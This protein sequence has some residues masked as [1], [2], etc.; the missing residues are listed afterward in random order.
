[1]KSPDASHLL[2]AIKEDELPEVHGSSFTPNEMMDEPDD[3]SIIASFSKTQESFLER[4]LVRATTEMGQ[5]HATALRQQQQ[6]IHHLRQAMQTMQDKQD[7]LPTKLPA[8]ME[9]PRVPETS[10][11]RIYEPP[12]HCKTS[13]REE[14]GTR[15]AP[16]QYMVYTWFTP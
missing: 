9:T 5:V 11:P 4:I 3:A 13:E 12:G 6:E 7:T 16:S 1:M 8:M 14:R 10:R 2:F 15:T